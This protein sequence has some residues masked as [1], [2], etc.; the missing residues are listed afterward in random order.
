MGA[1]LFHLV[2]W[3]TDD[4]SYNTFELQLVDYEDLPDSAIFIVRGYLE[5]GKILSDETDII[6][7][8]S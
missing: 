7:F 1:D 6:I 5:S 8:T 4:H 2:M 3:L